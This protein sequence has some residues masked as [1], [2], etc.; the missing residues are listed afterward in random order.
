MISF[1]E[2]GNNSLDLISTYLD[3]Q[4]RSIYSIF[5][6]CAP[7]LKNILVSCMPYCILEKSKNTRTFPS[8]YFI[9]LLFPLFGSKSSFEIDITIVTM[10]VIMIEIHFFTKIKCII[11]KYFIEQ[12]SKYELIRPT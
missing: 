10:P 6:I 7:I 4:N 5:H 12:Y 8:I 2:T 3:S 11:F 9:P 1:K